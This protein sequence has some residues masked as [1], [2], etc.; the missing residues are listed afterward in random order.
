[1]LR[2]TALA[3]ALIALCLVALTPAH[4]ARGSSAAAGAAPLPP[5]LSGNGGA[6]EVHANKQWVAKEVQVNFQAAETDASVWGL[7]CPPGEQTVHFR[8]KLTLPGPGA[9]GQFTITPFYGNGWL[10]RP[11]LKSWTSV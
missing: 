6:F 5:Y 8:R 4:G 1:M 7:T 10:N 2:W 11:P 9:D 3:G